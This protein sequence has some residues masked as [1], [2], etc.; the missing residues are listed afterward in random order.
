MPYSE[1]TQEQRDEFAADLGALAESLSL[2]NGTLGL[3]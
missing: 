2:L 3:E 1:V